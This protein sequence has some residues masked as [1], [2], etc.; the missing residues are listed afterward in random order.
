VLSRLRDRSER[1][2]VSRCSSAAPTTIDSGTIHSHRVHRRRT[3]V[4]FIDENP[5][6]A[7]AE[8]YEASNR[9]LAQRVPVKAL[10]REGGEQ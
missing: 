8:D 3:T 10:D 2:R 7:F 6:S 5:L 4:A 1:H 9:R